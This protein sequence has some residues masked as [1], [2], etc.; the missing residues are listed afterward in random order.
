MCLYIY[1]ESAFA[2]VITSGTVGFN[3]KGSSG[4]ATFGAARGNG[5]SLIARNGNW[6]VLAGANTGVTLA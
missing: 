2:H 3:A 4:T 6:Y 5:V 1:S